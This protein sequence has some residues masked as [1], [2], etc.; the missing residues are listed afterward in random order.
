MRKRLITTGGTIDKVYN[1]INGELVFDGT[2]VPEM[3][4]QARVDLSRV[5]IEDLMR[6]DSLDM[7]AEERDLIAISCSESAERQIIVTHGTDT[8]P[9]T[10]QHIK[11]FFL[12]RE[13]GH[14][15]IILTGAMI[16]FNVTG[17]DALFNLGTAF[18]SVEQVP[19]GVFVS[20]NGKLLEA[21]IAIKD[22]ERGVFKARP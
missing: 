15:S 19:D 16:P 12:D 5:I 17:S 1:P 13:I 8:M 2:H 18:A 6:I 4:T 3:L 7:T 22:R 14:R 11:S 9:E 10:A 21:D 20:M